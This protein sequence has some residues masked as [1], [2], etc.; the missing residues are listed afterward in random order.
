MTWAWHVQR[1]SCEYVG[2]VC[3]FMTG[4]VLLLNDI[5]DQSWWM[6]ER[7][8]WAVARAKITISKLGLSTIY[9]DIS[10]H[11]QHSAKELRLMPF[12]TPVPRTRSRCYLAV[13]LQC[14]LLELPHSRSRRHFSHLRIQHHRNKIHLRKPEVAYF[15]IILCVGLRGYCH[16][17]LIC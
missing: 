5:Y 9:T 11:Q 6:F 10:Y 4:F 7:R 14:S 8:S 15:N 1:L 17:F 16:T 3:S 13:W 12:R 2:K